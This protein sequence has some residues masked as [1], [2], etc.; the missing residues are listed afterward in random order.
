MFRRNS[1]GTQEEASEESG[2]RTGEADPHLVAEESETA[3]ESRP[4]DQQ[5]E[6]PQRGFSPGG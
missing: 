3:S 4:N 2:S 1:Q 5:P 6:A